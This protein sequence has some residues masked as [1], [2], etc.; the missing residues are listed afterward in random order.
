MRIFL[1]CILLMLTAGASFSQTVKNQ[2]SHDSTAQMYFGT[3][4]NNQEESSNIE[5]LHSAGSHLHNYRVTMTV[6]HVLALL[7]GVMFGAGLSSQSVESAQT[8][9]WAGGAAFLISSIIAWSG[10]RNIGKAGDE[11]QAIHGEYIEDQK[12][13]SEEHK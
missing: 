3:N 11:L 4:S 9:Y 13:K 5:H 10:P 8:F 7:G 12:K 6:S 2:Y 1:I